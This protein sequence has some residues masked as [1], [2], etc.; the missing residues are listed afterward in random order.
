MSGMKQ[1]LGA[2]ALSVTAVQTGQ[3]DSNADVRIDLVVVLLSFSD[4]FRNF[5]SN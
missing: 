4:I 5:P 2:T 1:S 3:V